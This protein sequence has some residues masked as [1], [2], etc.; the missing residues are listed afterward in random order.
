[1]EARVDGRSAL[2]TGGSK[3]L[4]LAMAQELAASG[5][6][7]AIVAR[8]P[9]RL[10]AAKAAIAAAGGA[11]VHTVAA[12]PCRRNGWR[13]NHFGVASICTR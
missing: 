9:E 1:M 13:A 8:G 11:R 6:E 5:A 2:I 4:G 12:R 7:V 10:A 3:G